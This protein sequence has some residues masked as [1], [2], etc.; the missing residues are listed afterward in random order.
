MVLVS[1][2]VLGNRM[3]L[4]LL[5]VLVSRMD[6][7]NRMF[8]VLLEVLVGLEHPLQLAVSIF[9]HHHRRCRQR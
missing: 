9:Y 5:E 3:V 2:E 6:L 7:E 8:L 1:L 4:V